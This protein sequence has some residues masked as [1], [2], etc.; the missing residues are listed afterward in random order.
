MNAM[1]VEQPVSIMPSKNASLNS[2]CTQSNNNV[3]MVCFH[4]KCNLSD[5]H[6]CDNPK[7]FLRGLVR[8]TIPAKD[9]CDFTIAEKS[10]YVELM[11]SI[12]YRTWLIIVRRND[13]WIEVASYKNSIAGKEEEIADI[14]LN[15]MEMLLSGLRIMK[16]PFGRSICTKAQNGS[17]PLEN[18]AFTD[19][20]KRKLPC[21][22]VGY[23]QAITDSLH[24]KSL[25][26]KST[27]VTAVFAQK[28]K[29]R[30][31]DY[32]Q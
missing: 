5:G 2:S 9:I 19:D 1:A 31:G 18:G 8:N 12:L 26:L 21:L 28:C 17:C 14:I 32:G 30:K 16:A 10:K 4:P 13:E 7:D 6:G 3:K 23:I 15:Y 27:D 29:R 20:I 25:H 22:S 11:Y 24:L